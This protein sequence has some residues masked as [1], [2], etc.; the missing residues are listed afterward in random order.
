MPETKGNK[1]RTSC[2]LDISPDGIATL[3]EPTTVALEGSWIDL[4]GSLMAAASTWKNIQC[5]V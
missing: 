5:N 4:D 3:S 2:R 1:C